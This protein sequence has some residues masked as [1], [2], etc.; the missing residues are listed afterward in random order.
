MPQV[1]PIPEGYRTLTPSLRIRGAARAME[2][3]KQAFGAEEVCRMAGPDGQSIMHAE[4]KIGDSM[5]M[6]CDE[7]PQWGALGPAS[8]NG[9]SVGIHVYTPDVDA[10][11]RRAEA[12]G[13]T[14]IMP[15]AD[16]FWGDR[17]AKLK[18]PFGHEWSIATHKED[19]TP[20]QMAPRM[21]AAMKEMCGSASKAP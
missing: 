7:M 18:D 3:Y 2:F 17:F 10:A 16:M 4:L 9:T 15:P 21:E 11:V 5:V 19:L 12:A 6:L 14:V 8:L 13:A 1:N 20:E